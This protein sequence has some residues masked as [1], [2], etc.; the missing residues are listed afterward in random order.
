MKNIKVLGID[1][2]KNV[3]QLHGADSKGK[4]V[5]RKRLGREKLIEF[6]TN[7]LPC[8]IGIEA[9]T[10][11]HHWA[12]LFEKMGHTVKMMAPQFVKPYVRSN[13]NDRNDARAIAEAVGRPDMKF[14][15][16]KKIE[17]QDILY[18]I[19]QEHW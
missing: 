12:R 18:C 16:I 19:V 6:V 13:K 15:P 3:F 8:V 11:A 17:Q 10:G 1:L 2:A 4:C 14:V 5:L 7:L 9:C